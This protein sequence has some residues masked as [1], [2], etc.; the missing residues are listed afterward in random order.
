MSTTKTLPA[1]VKVPS[2][3]ELTASPAVKPKETP[4]SP[5]VWLPFE[6]EDYADYNPTTPTKDCSEEDT[7]M[8]PWCP[9]KCS[10]GSMAHIKWIIDTVK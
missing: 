3:F 10:Y 2:V 4:F 5:P 7:H 8:T 1:P 6:D 9:L